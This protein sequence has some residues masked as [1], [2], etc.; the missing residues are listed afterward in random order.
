MCKGMGLGDGKPA[1]EGWERPYTEG[2]LT[3]AELEQ[4]WRDGYVVKRD[5]LSKEQLQPV[6][7][8]IARCRLWCSRLLLGHCCGP[9]PS[10]HPLP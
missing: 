7:D 4:Y 8:S 9:A 2:V 5:L 3:K 6:I 10:P 1:I